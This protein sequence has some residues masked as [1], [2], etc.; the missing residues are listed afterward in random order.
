MTLEGL[1]PQNDAVIHLETY[2]DQIIILLQDREKNDGFAIYKILVLK[3]YG[4]EIIKQKFVSSNFKAPIRW[5]VEEP[6]ILF[7]THYGKYAWID[8]KQTSIDNPFDGRFETTKEPI[9][10]SF[11]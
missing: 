11:L 10:I 6:G 7:L 4:N 9:K 8:L 1:N 3:Q 5:N 2:D